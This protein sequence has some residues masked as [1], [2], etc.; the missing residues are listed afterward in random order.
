MADLS[1]HAK[2]EHA[3]RLFCLGMFEQS[4]Q[5]IHRIRLQEDQKTVRISNSLYMIC[6]ARCS[7]IFLPGV[8]CV[9]K[10][11]N[12]GAFKKALV[13]KRKPSG[14]FDARFKNSL[15]L[16]TFSG[17]HQ[18]PRKRLGNDDYVMVYHCNNCSYDIIFDTH[19]FTHYDFGPAL[20]SKSEEEKVKEKDHALAGDKSKEQIKFVVKQILSKPEPPKTNKGAQLDLSAFLKKLG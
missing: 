1:P 15:L 2:W 17:P 3:V 16:S 6:C 11:R 7:L 19:P 13:R 20:Q 10:M 12:W 8:T 4:R 9:V 5:I 18:P 14:C